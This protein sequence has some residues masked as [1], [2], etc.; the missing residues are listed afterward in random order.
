MIKEIWIGFEVKSY[1]DT[2]RRVCTSRVTELV[3]VYFE[4]KLYCKRW[5]RCNQINEKI[6]WVTVFKT[7]FIHLMVVS[8]TTEK[9]FTGRKPPLKGGT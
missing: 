8:Y 5:N 4:D 6:L 3:L 2:R 9:S 7:A 1:D